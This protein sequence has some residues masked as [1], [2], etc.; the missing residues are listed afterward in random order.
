MAGTRRSRVKSTDSDADGEEGSSSSTFTAAA[1]DGGYDDDS[2][3]AAEAGG[4]DED[5]CAYDNVDGDAAGGGVRRPRP[6]RH[7]MCAAGV[8]DLLPTCYESDGEQSP[9]PQPQPQLHLRGLNFYENLSDHDDHHANDDDDD[10][11]DSDSIENG[12]MDDGEYIADAMRRGS[13]FATTHD[14]GSSGYLPV[15]FQQADGAGDEDAERGYD[16]HDDGDE[17]VHTRGQVT[18]MVSPGTAQRRTKPQHQQHQQHQQCRAVVRGRDADAMVVEN[19]TSTPMSERSLSPSRSRPL[20]P[21]SASM[22]STPIAGVQ[23]QDLPPH[24]PHSSRTPQYKYIKQRKTA[25][26]MQ[27]LQDRVLSGQVSQL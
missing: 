27:R 5:P 17:A 8:V 7:G 19:G 12:G 24:L 22:P 14:P 15:G 23:R 9:Q 4:D 13:H 16:S 18:A 11:D 21:T 26:V 2:A 20:S 3:D 10:D 6:Q 25:R 1:T